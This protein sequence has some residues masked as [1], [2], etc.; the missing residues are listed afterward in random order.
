MKG[1]SMTETK[2]DIEV[3]PGETHPNILI[4]APHG[5]NGDDDNT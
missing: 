2:K 4:I 1:V 3:I 5:V